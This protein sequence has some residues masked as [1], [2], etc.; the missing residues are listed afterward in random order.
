MLELDQ[1]TG[2]SWVLKIEK[3]TC[4]VSGQTSPLWMSS[5]LLAVESQLELTF[6]IVSLFHLLKFFHVREI[7]TSLKLK[8]PE[9]WSHGGLKM[10]WSSLEILFY[11]LILSVLTTLLWKFSPSQGAL[12]TLES[13]YLIVKLS[14][15]LSPICHLLL[16]FLCQKVTIESMIIFQ[17]TRSDKVKVSRT[18]IWATWSHPVTRLTKRQPSSPWRTTFF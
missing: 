17:T 9:M 7:E 1:K 16:L 12:S 13:T 18:W 5:H 2:L 6:R 14:S 3:I 11:L 4:C 8:R 15:F 10:K